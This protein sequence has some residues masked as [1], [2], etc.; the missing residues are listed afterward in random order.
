MVMNAGTDQFY[1]YGDDRVLVLI[2]IASEPHFVG[3][4]LFAVCLEAV[5]PASHTMLL[6]AQMTTFAFV[7]TLTACEEAPAFST[8]W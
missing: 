3:C 2:S 1:D 7:F 8:L 4:I 6:Y 5:K